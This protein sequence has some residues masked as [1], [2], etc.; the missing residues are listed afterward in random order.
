MKNQRK[1]NRHKKKILFKKSN[2]EVLIPKIEDKNVNESVLK[3]PIAEEKEIKQEIV[4]EEIKLK[5]K[6]TSKSKPK[7]SPTKKAKPKPK[8][9][10]KDKNIEFDLPD[11]LLIEKFKRVNV[12]EGYEENRVEIYLGNNR[13]VSVIVE[14]DNKRIAIILK[15]KINE[16]EG[17]SPA[18]TR[19][20]KRAG[21]RIGFTEILAS[22]VA[23]YCIYLAIQELIKRKMY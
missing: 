16:N 14:K 5:T 10:K 2:T 17:Y 3:S 19:I 8:K 12:I 20:D 13:K 11:D 15:R 4:L 22:R 9:E 6:K 7:K 18:R 1:P 21:I 23:G